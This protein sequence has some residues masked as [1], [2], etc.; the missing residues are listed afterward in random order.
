MTHRPPEVPDGF[1]RYLEELNTRFKEFAEQAQLPVADDLR[2]LGEQLTAATAVPDAVREFAE[3]LTQQFEQ[4][5][6]PPVLAA[7]SAVHPP[8]VVTGRAAGHI[9]FT[10]EAT[11]VVVTPLSPAG[12]LAWRPDL[13]IAAF[14]VFAVLSCYGQSFSEAV[15]DGLRELCLVYLG[16][17]VPA[18]LLAR[19]GDDD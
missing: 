13:L 16:L 7:T 2:R 3:A 6:Q 17:G 11:G 19:R 9:E 14:V 5:V 12:P 1:R 15:A 8:T 18:T 4:V 10:A